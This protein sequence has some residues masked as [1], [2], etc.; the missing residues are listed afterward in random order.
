MLDEIPPDETAKWLERLESAR[1]GDRESLAWLLKNYW[2]PM[3]EHVGGDLQSA[4]P[5]SGLVQETLVEAQNSLHDFRGQ[6]PKELRT[7]LHTILTNNIRDAWGA[8]GTDKR[9][10]EVGIQNNEAIV[11]DVVST[12]VLLPATRVTNGNEAVIEQISN[13]TSDTSAVDFSEFRPSNRYQ[14]ISRLGQGGFGVVFLAHDQHLNRNVALKM[15]RPDVLLTKS[16]IQRFLREARN[17]AKLDHPNIVPVLATDETALMPSIVYPYCSGPTLGEWLQS[18]QSPPD[19]RVVATIVKLLA[20]AVQH[21]HAR[22]ILHRDLKLAN[23]LL[24]PTTECDQHYCFNDGEASWIPRVTDFGISKATQ[25]EDDETVTGSV[26]GT[27]EY[28][29]PE[30]IRGLASD[31]GSHSDVYS[32]GV[33]L[34]ELLVKQRPYLSD[35][36]ADMILKMKDAGPPL[37]RKLRQEVP[38]DLEA[39]VTRCLSVSIDHRYAT[40]AGL[41]EDLGSF[42]HCRPVLARKNSVAVRIAHW[43]RRQPVVAALS[44]ICAVLAF[45]AIAGAISY[46]RH[47]NSSGSAL[48]A[49]NKQLQSSRDL[50]SAE[51][52][53]G[54]KSAAELR[55]QLYAADITAAARALEEGDLPNYDI[56]LK[57]QIK[58][59]PE[60][61]LREL[62]W[63]HLWNK[64]HRECESIAVSK[65]PLYSV[66]FSNRGDLIA[67]CGEEGFVS[68]YDAR[69]YQKLVSWNAEQG[70]VNLAS[71]SAD[72]KMIA[73]AGDDGTVCVWNSQTGKTLNRFRAHLK[74]AFHSLFGQ[75]DLLI[76]CGNENVI[77][78]WNWRTGEAIKELKAHTKS[79][80]SISLSAD[81]TELYSASDDG[82]RGIWNLATMQLA[83]RLDAVESRALDVQPANG[84][85]FIFSS[86]LHGTV[87]R[88][89]LATQVEFPNISIA[90]VTDSA[91]CIAVSSDCRRVAV[92][93]RTGIICLVELDE[94]L[95]PINSSASPVQ[96]SW[97][98]HPGRIYDLAFS[99]DGSKLN[100]VGHDG[101]LRTWKIETAAH[102]ASIDV[103][104]LIEPNRNGTAVVQIAPDACIFSVARSLS[105]WR[106]TA[107]LM[108]PMAMTETTITRIAG[109]VSKQ[110]VFAGEDGGRLRAWWWKE[111]QLE[112]AWSFAWHDAPRT[113][114]GLAYSEERNWIASA[115]ETPRNR[116]NLI[117]AE[118]GKEIRELVLPKSA[119]GN[120]E[121]DLA[122]SSDGKWLAAAINNQVFVWDLQTM[123]DAKCLSGHTSTVTAISFHPNSSLLASGS[124]DRAVKVWDVAAETQVADLRR[125]TE[126]VTSVLFSPDGKSLLSC[127]RDGC[128]AVW[129]TESGRFLLEMDNHKRVVKLSRN[130]FGPMLFRVREFS[131]VHADFL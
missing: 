69:T 101:V 82:T 107:S 1:Q 114:T 92:A 34:Y 128:T 6:T 87:R 116:V 39:I 90:K 42:L 106:P 97:S 63:Y 78:V 23:V 28:M 26:M 100:S 56:L 38:R 10:P 52:D 64:G 58:L 122:F 105:L 12:A 16:M 124:S 111:N 18:R 88:E 24:E 95:I 112:P 11:T 89:S 77:R 36:C 51:R 60:E 126:A 37:V 72:D 84:F 50:A 68:V 9:Q 118:T 15:P 127:D 129:H 29:A 25:A 8:T 59:E 98:A 130:W 123:R 14:L 93:N 113:L 61:D 96:R 80:Q 81:R 2:Q 70:E 55:N 121:G 46:M 75:G 73:T 41:A 32:L 27:L 47:A 44:G 125:H 102:R 110:M 99:P 79:V 48:F 30:Q 117:D 65:L 3:W 74:Q 4:R 85:P 49:I 17:V 21:A 91:Q 57:R 120:N 13:L 62:A 22:G 76:S 104:H 86:D 7:W 103:T 19:F 40:A 67:V 53:R 131:S 108:A 31:I 20:E 35:S 43:V 83:R 66:Q 5:E 109:S 94:N 71:F 54:T 45:V 119:Q 115:I 33:I